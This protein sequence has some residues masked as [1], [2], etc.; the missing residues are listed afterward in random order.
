MIG[1]YLTEINVTSPTGAVALKTFSG[2]DATDI[3]LGSGLKA[4]APRPR[5]SR[6][7]AACKSRKRLVFPI[8]SIFVLDLS[9]DAVLRSCG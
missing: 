5:L 4:F 3:A 6:E 1:D 2:I 8:S 9:A 7:D